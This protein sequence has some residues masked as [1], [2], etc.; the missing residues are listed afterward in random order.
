[1]AKFTINNTK[2]EIEC[3]KQTLVDSLSNMSNLLEGHETNEL[4]E[5]IF[6]K[7][8]QK[9]IEEVLNFCCERFPRQ[10]GIILEENGIIEE[11]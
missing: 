10:T 3:T 7:L 2:T 5:N 11:D 4:L 1:M 6:S 8:T 9:Q